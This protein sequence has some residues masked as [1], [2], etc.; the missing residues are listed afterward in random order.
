MKEKWVQTIR[1][2]NNDNYEGG[3]F[4]CQQHFASEDIMHISNQKRLR[5]GSIPSVF[6]VEIV[7]TTGSTTIETE[8]ECEKCECLE[9]ERFELFDKFTK[10]NIESQIDKERFQRKIDQQQTTIKEKAKEIEKLQHQ[11]STLKNKS[12]DLQEQILISKTSPGPKVYT[13]IHNLSTY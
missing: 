6:L 5:K 4:I 12:K 13:K 11:L 9:K 7:E 2:A 8:H 10:L 3:G 1:A